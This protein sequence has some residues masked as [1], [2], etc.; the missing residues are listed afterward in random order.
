MTD[1]ERCVPLVDNDGQVVASVRMTGEMDEQTRQAWLAVVA[2]VHRMDAEEDKV[3]P[4][5]G[6][7]QQAAIERIR[8]RARRRRGEQP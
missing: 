4:D 3:D 8:E 6:A 7:R 1:G 5:R 2:A